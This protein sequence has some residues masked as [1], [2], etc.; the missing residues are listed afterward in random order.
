MGTYSMYL[1][2]FET[3]VTDNYR[4]RIAVMFQWMRLRKRKSAQP[5]VVTTQR[6]V[7]GTQ[8][9]PFFFRA[10]VIHKSW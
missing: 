8:R 9:K 6:A 3:V 4:V 7:N 5:I 1:H 2:K 10:K